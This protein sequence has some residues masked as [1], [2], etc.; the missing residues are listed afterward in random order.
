MPLVRLQTTVPLDDEQRLALARRLSSATAWLLG[1]PEAYTMAVVEPPA[2][3]VLGGSDAPAA[4]VDVRAVGTITAE[5]ARALS[6]EYAKILIA[7]LSVEPKR[8]YATFAG[9]PPTLWGH[10]EETFG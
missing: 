9:V 3:V 10:G 8:I 6:H 1:K 2:T 4:L 5:Q 7:T